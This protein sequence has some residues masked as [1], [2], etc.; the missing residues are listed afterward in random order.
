MANVNF[1]YNHRNKKPPKP[2]DRLPEFIKLPKYIAHQLEEHRNTFVKQTYKIEDVIF[3]LRLN[4][5]LVC[6]YEF[7]GDNGYIIYLKGVI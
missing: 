6:D 5:G 1:F 2:I 7:D 4:N 3:T